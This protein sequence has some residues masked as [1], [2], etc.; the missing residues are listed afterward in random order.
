MSLIP[1]PVG[2]MPAINTTAPP[3]GTMLQ[4]YRGRLTEGIC[5]HLQTVHQL[6]EPAARSVATAWVTAGARAKG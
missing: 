1:C 3:C 6:P 4:P 2:R 5:A